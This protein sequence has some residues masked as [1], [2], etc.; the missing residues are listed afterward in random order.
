MTILNLLRSLKVATVYAAVALALLL[1]G[2][3]SMRAQA[4]CTGERVFFP[5]DDAVLRKDYLSNEAALA[6]IDSLIAAGVAD[7]LLVRSWSS[8]EGNYNYN[9]SLSRRRAEAV[10]RYLQA[11]YPSLQGRVSIDPSSESWD[12]LRAAIIADSRLSDDVRDAM[13]EIVDADL[14]PDTK[15]RR[16]SVLPVWKQFYRNW[17]RKFRLAE[18]SFPALPE[19]KQAVDSL[20]GGHDLDTAAVAGAAIVPADTLGAAAPVD[21]A[22]IAPADTLAAVAAA[23]S[24]CAAIAPADTPSAVEAPDEGV[25]KSVVFALRSSDIDEVSN[26]E[27]LSAIESAIDRDADEVSGIV[28]TGYASPEGS[29]SYNEALAARRA[30]SLRDRILRKYPALAGKIEISNRGEDWEGFRKLVAEDA[31]LS[32]AERDEILAIL[33]SDLSEQAREAKLRSL[34]SWD[35]L[36]ANTMPQL[37]RTSLSARFSPVV[38][39]PAPADTTSV[40]ETPV[41]VV[42]VVVPTPEIE[43]D[44][45]STEI[46]IADTTAALADTLSVEPLA[47]PAGPAP[48]YIKKPLF[49]VGSNVV[50][51]MLITP[52]IAVEVPIGRN[53]SAYAEYTFPW[54]VTKGNDRAWEMLKWDLGAR[55]WFSRKDKDDPMDVLRG[56]SLSAELS[57]G[58]YDVEPHHTG[59]QGEFLA[60]SLLYGYAWKLSP[61]WRMEAFVGVGWMGTQFRYYEATQDDK[62]LIYQ[63][64]GNMSWFGPTKV[65]LTFKYLFTRRVRVDKPEMTAR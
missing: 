41:V 7:S 15:E 61:S 39:T 12:E 14:A 4:V 26:A 58:Y 29:A 24:L 52:H 40:E 36:L 57:A 34:S 49:A 1:G 9:L 60:A 5:F 35:Y 45:D 38:Q 53:W 32:E 62:H 42:P 13:L 18:V 6:R 51:D 63:R 55:W 10:R 3:F 43:V 48:V 28:L 16:L 2:S 37:R 65:G 30:A 47:V 17:F 31:S 22:A 33:D 21:T 19:V 8:P 23:D 27:A 46:E 64:D 59:Y 54:W 50:S 11:K 20:A 56:H 44:I 25:S